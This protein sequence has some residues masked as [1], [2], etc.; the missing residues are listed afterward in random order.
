MWCVSCPGGVLGCEVHLLCFALPWFPGLI[1]PVPFLFLELRALTSFQEAPILLR[2]PE[3]FFVATE[4][5]VNSTVTL[6]LGG[7]LVWES[8][9]VCTSAV[10]TVTERSLSWPGRR[11]PWQ[12][13]VSS[14]AGYPVVSGAPKEL[15]GALHCA[16]SDTAVFTLQ[17]RWQGVGRDSAARACLFPVGQVLSIIHQTK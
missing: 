9:S 1:V 7:C 4:L 10:V 16:E 11:A 14:F 3:S 17:G 12:G 15:L 13:V 5:F 6:D 8:T 2:Y